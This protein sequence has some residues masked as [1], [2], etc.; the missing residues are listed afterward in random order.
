MPE[1]GCSRPQAAGAAALLQEVVSK[2]HA[3]ITEAMKVVYGDILSPPQVRMCHYVVRQTNA[4]GIE[5]YV[6]TSFG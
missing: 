5:G 4:S 3:L 1:S 6:R 2:E